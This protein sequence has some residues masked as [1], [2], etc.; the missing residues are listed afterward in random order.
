[1]TQRPALLVLVGLVIATLLAG[2]VAL[3]LFGRLQKRI[4]RLNADLAIYQSAKSVITMTLTDA[5]TVIQQS[6]DGRATACR[7]LADDIARNGGTNPAEIS[8]RWNFCPNAFT[9]QANTAPSFISL[10]LKA[11][12]DRL[13]GNYATAIGLYDQALDA[14]KG[15]PNSDWLVRG[16]E[17]RAYSRFSL[18][19]LDAAEADIDRALE[20][21]KRIDGGYVYAYTT[22]AKIKCRSRAHPAAV[23]NVIAEARRRLEELRGR[24][25]V[26]ALA[27]HNAELD[28]RAIDDDAQLWSVCGYAKLKPTA[29]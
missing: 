10:Y 2:V 3:I 21:G 24:S 5:S 7:L 19:Q 8:V 1:M 11:M 16:L 27:R 14:L 6:Y 12:S 28:L 22:S 4:E 26:S 29:S 13:N 23:R 20:A 25:G 18:G 15:D 17:G 9:R